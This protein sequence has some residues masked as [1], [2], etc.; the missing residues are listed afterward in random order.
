[1]A[2][3]AP[4]SI[5]ASTQA[6]HRVV[7]VAGDPLVRAGLTALLEGQPTLEVVAQ[8]SPQEAAESLD[9]YQPAA[10]IW[11]ASDDE[12]ALVGIH[13]PVLS[14]VAGQTAAAQSWSAGARGL[15]LRDASGPALAA[16]IAAMVHG[17]AVLDPSLLG[18][19]RPAPS[20]ALE[21]LP[22]AMTPREVEV[23]RLLAEGLPNKTIADRLGVTE[24]TVKFHVNAIMGKLAAQSRTDAVIRA[25]RLGLITL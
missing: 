25:T 6:R 18:A 19:I 12:E 9:I 7:V 17:Q 1:M 24:H 20:A 11:A 13:I 23:L 22:E 8:L 5:A 10:A 14:L 21:S 3:L 2:F 15:L 4:Q 16:A